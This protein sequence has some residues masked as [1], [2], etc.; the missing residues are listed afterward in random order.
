MKKVHFIGI[1]GSLCSAIAIAAKRAGFDVSGCDHLSSLYAGQV[2]DAGI[3]VENTHSVDHIDD[4]DIV[5]ASAAL[6]EQKNSVPEIERA[7]NVGKLIKIQEFLSKYLLANKRLIAIAGTHGKTTTAS[8][9]AHVMEEAGFDP[10]ALIGAIVPKWNSSS[11]FGNSEWVV[12]E[13]DEYANNFDSYNPE[14]AILNNLEMEHPEYF[15]DWNHYK[16]TFVDFLSKAKTIIYNRDDAG[17]LEIL[18]KIKAEKIPFSAA[19]F[20]SGLK[21]SLMGRHNRGNAMAALTLARYLGI[22]EPVARNAVESFQ[23]AGHR[24]QK[25]FDNGNLVV[26]DD[27]AHHHTQVKNTID[28][29]HENYPDYKLVAVFEPHQIS[30]YAQNTKDTLATLA[31][32][33]WA[34]VTEFWSGR[35]AHLPIPNVDADI[36]KFDIKNVEYVPNF[37]EVV[38]RVKKQTAHTGKTVIVVMGAGKSYKISE[39]LIL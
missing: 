9:I 3:P 4:A 24:L 28:A 12:L 31:L 30:R 17:V 27:Y 16:K 14:I 10:T 32:A 6:L 8:M 35:E 13:A 2:L 26:F 5:A 7:I 15:R 19:D 29:L 39:K 1:N 18:P 22:S 25:V 38:A 37:D 33:D 21:M 20:P 11:R 34:Y 23:G 36:K